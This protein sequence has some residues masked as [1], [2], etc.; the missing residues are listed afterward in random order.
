MRA[1]LW[2]DGAALRYGL[3]G[4][5]TSALDLGL[6]TVFASG[7]GR[8]VVLA[9]VMSTLITV[10]VAYLIHRT[11]VFRSSVPMSVRQFVSFASVTLFTGLVVQSALIWLGVSVAVGLGATHGS[12]LVVVG[13]KILAM[14]GAALCNYVA[15]GLLF[16][17]RGRS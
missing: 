3:V 16:A 15:Y 17:R 6:F 10:C 13:V 2:R 7:L 1:W 11:F 9:N 14:A 8:H 4:L 12:V 5:S